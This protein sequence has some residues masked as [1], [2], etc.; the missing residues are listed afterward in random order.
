MLPIIK[1]SKIVEKNLFTQHLKHWAKKWCWGD[2]GTGHRT[3][4]TVDRQMG[5]MERHNTYCNVHQWQWLW[6]RLCQQAGVGW[7]TWD[8]PRCWPWRHPSQCNSAS[9]SAG[10]TMEGWRDRDVVWELVRWTWSPGHNLVTAGL[11]IHLHHVT[12]IMT[13]SPDQHYKNISVNWKHNFGNKLYH[14]VR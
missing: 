2:I 10:H 1:L 7:S 6:V 3:R 13:T 11:M 14:L 8:C 12:S 9:S 5:D 4:A